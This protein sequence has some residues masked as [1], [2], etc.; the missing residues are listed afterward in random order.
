[1][2]ISRRELYERKRLSMIRQGVYSFIYY[3]YWDFDILN[4]IL[5][6][7][8][9]R[10][11]ETINDVLIMADTE[12]SKEIPGHQCRNY[13]VAWTIS[14]RAFDTNIITLYGH[15]PSEMVEAIGKMITAMAGMKTYIYFHNLPYDWV[16]IRKFCFREW[17]EPLHQL[18][19]KSHQPIYIE[20]GNGIVFR[21]SLILAQ[22]SL[23]KW[24]EDMD[25]KHKK[26]VGYWDYDKIRHQDSRFT[27]HE[28]TYIEHDTLA[29]VE[30]LQATLDSLHKSIAHVPFTATGIPREEVQKRAK[31]NGGRDLFLKLVPTWRVQQILEMVYHG[32]YTHANRHYVEELITG[33]IKAYDESSAYPY[34]M[35]TE[36]MPMGRFTPISQP[37]PPEFILEHADEYAYIFRLVMLK[38]RLKSNHIP[39]PVLQKSKCVKIVDGVE[40]NGRLLC[41]GYCEIW[42]NEID[43]ELIYE[44]YDLSGGAVCLDIHYAV[45]DYLPRWFTDYVYECFKEKTDL[46]PDPVTGKFDPVA[47][48]MAKSKLNSL[49]GLSVTHPVKLIIDEN[50]QT[51]KFDIMEGQDEES[52]Y[53][54]YIENRNSVLCY[55]WG[56]W[57]TSAAMR[58]LMTIGKNAG[59]WLYSDT[60]SC[61]G[62]DWNENGIKAYNEECKRKLI[63]RGYPGVPHGDKEYWLGVCEVDGEY[64]EF[65]TVGAKRYACRKKKDGKIKITV[66]GVPKKGFLSL[67]DDLRN[68]KSGF[69]FDG[70]TSGK[71]QHS[72]YYEDDIWEDEHGNE[73]GDSIDLSPASYLLDSV[74]DVNWEKLFEEEIMTVVYDDRL[75]RGIK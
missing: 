60:D 15:K 16:F 25:V 38:P 24:S 51:G 34:A 44:Q 47:Y 27:P 26:A 67:K 11:E 20:F 68:F 9:R 71:L 48:S 43:L 35:L 29:G 54:K 13:V 4:N 33:Y 7:P 23:D 58:N 10:G 69:I 50:Y 18:N 59:V 70:E 66:S 64:S 55:Q 3:K 49:Y 46:K 65:I 8:V 75:I 53:K 12:T 56:C 45:K 31:A 52:L 42:L 74:S 39:M 32:G 5:Y 30:C 17:G 63:E 19:I 73:R 57:V 2:T 1:M 72:Y 40:D 6:I 21:D 14:I 41:C 61:Y 22:R 37:E 28:K 36:K 62:M